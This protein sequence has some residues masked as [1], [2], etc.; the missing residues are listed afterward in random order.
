MKKIV[1]ITARKN[2]R[3]GGRGFTLVE[4]MVVIATLGVLAAVILPALARPDDNGARA[5]CMNNLRQMGMAASLYASDNSDYLAF[6]NWDGGSY[7]APGWLYNVSAETPQTL[8]NPYDKNPWN[9]PGNFN[10]AWKNGLW[11]KYLNN[12][13][14]Y[15]CPVD[16]ES[17]SFRQKLGRNNKLSSYVMNGAVCGYSS[18]TPVRTCKITDVWSPA[19]WLLWEPDENT[20]GL[21]NPGGFEFNDGANYPS[22]PP[23]GSEGIGRLH[24]ANSGDMLCVG[25]N[26][27]L[28][29]VQTF[30][31]QSNIPSGHGPGPGG[32]TLAWWNP[33]GIPGH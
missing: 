22:A 26:V 7:V 30:A 27:Q 19:C 31:Y 11:F 21:R 24:S 12:P 6:P 14:S 8:P 10:S 23:T 16:I 2:A 5:V 33:F 29:T 15:Y 1:A 28:V 32:K 4:L 17:A 3:A 20:V 13:N 25:G 18:T 9:L